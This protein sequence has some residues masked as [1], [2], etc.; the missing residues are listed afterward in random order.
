MVKQETGLGPHRTIQND[1]RVHGVIVG[2]QREDAR[3]LLIRRSATVA[4]PLRVCFPG[5]GIDGEETQE[6]AAVREMHEELSAPITPLSCVWQ[7]VAPDRPLT[8]WGWHAE[9]QSLD[10]VANS[11]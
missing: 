8:L 10:V 2:C 9:L 11:M 4:M 3:W 7:L 5:G 6:Q 1:G